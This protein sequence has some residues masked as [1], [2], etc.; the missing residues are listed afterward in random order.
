[1][2]RVA[3]RPCIVIKT[4]EDML[5]CQ[6]GP[7]RKTPSL[8]LWVQAHWH[9]LWGFA[10]PA[11]TLEVMSFESA[12]RRSGLLNQ[13]SPLV[14]NI[15]SLGGL[16]PG[17]R[18]W[19]EG[20]MLQMRSKRLLCAMRAEEMR[21]AE[22]ISVFGRPQLSK[23]LLARGPSL[24][25]TNTRTALRSFQGTKRRPNWLERFDKTPIAPLPAA[26]QH[27]NTIFKGGLE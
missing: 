13:F 27:W 24:A 2:C 10:L 21:D 15:R 3:G 7:G 14:Q 4:I 1:V 19:R 8:G 6:T 11:K 20:L 25:R 12:D 17:K 26:I 5:V 16:P 22:Y 9:I 23:R 18:R